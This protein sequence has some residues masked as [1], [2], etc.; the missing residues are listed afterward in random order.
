MTAG[1]STTV[2]IQVRT[3]PSTPHGTD[4]DNTATVS[5]STPEFNPGDESASTTT[6]VNQSPYGATDLS[7]QKSDSPDPVI[8]GEN[9]TY[10]LVVTNN[11][12]APATGVQVVDSLP[13]GVSYVTSS[14]T[15]GACSAGVL[16]LIGDMAV[17]ESVTITIIVRVDSDLTS[18]LSNL[19]FV[20]SLNPDS[21][22]D[23]NDDTEL[24]IVNLSADLSVTKTAD[25]SIA[26]PGAGL[27]YEIVVTNQGPSLAQN[28]TIQDLLPPDLNNNTASSSQGS[29][30]ITS[31][32]ILNCNLGNIPAG[33]Q[34]IVTVTGTVASDATETL[35][36]YVSVVC[37]PSEPNY[38]TSCEDN[39]QFVDTEVSANA[40]LSLVKTVSSPQVA[41]GEIFTYTITVQNAG[42]SLAQNVVVTDTLDTGVDYVSAVPI[43]LSQPDPVVWNL[44]S[45]NAGESRLIELVVQ[46]QADLPNG[47][48]L[49]NSA[50]VDSS[51]EDSNPGN[52][53]DDAQNQVFSESTITVEKTASSDPV[54]A[55]ESLVYTI[56]VHN[57]GPS[58]SWDVEI[59][60]LLPDG[61]TLVDVSSTQ[62]LC[63]GNPD[64]I[65]Q[66][67]D[68]PADSDVV[69]TIETT[70]DS[71]VPDGTQICNTAVKFP[72][73]LENPDG[74]SE[75]CV[76]VQ[77]EA[78]LRIEK[79]DSKDPVNAGEQFTYTI[80]VE[81]LGPSDAQAVTVSDTL[82]AEL[83]F[84]SANPV[85]NSGPNPLT[86]EPGCGSGQV[87]KR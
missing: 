47:R 76:D 29:C 31:D 19:A 39:E 84:I 77:A 59:K 41:G 33:E 81:N 32:S 56:N 7:I 8:A 79:A 86:L 74:S 53:S 26:T 4:I 55:G 25:P 63:I 83:N 37:Q 87:L 70:V 40:D 80:T 12:P 10:T 69:I 48:L 35:T 36:N 65:C 1:E 14:S 60:D 3:D 43:P 67:G 38:P 72:Q 57:S 27:S 16:C 71:D 17:G 66:I 28:V 73:E 11:G 42:P 13:A 44:G 15:K 6:T 18:G 34:V 5:S 49:V 9:L 85:Q 22:P 54:K 51:T 2:M 46:A 64:I 24:T 52:N 23:N 30:S 45:L 58:T 21:N 50:V 75:V 68:M 61:L 78:D 62:G 82:P 20:S